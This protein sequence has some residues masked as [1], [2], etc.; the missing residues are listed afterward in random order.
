MVFREN[1][2]AFENVN[3]NLYF[4]M[5]LSYTT[6]ATGILIVELLA[7]ALVISLVMQLDIINFF[8]IEKN[9]D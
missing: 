5:I 4:V 7:F 3:A 8:L 6:C 1:A 2:V 9:F